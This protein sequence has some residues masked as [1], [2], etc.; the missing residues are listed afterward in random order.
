MNVDNFIVRP[1]REVVEKFREPAVW[2]EP[3]PEEFDELEFIL[4]GLPTQQDPEDETA[5]RFDLLMLKSQLATLNKSS[6]FTK[7]RDQ[8][9]EIAS[10]LEEKRTI[11]MVNDQLDLILDLSRMSTGRTLRSRC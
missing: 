11:P 3:S 2:E 4:A 8:V 5:K 6:S 7:L 10:R 1:H 9:L